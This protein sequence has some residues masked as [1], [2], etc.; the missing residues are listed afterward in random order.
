M[1]DDGNNGMDRRNVLK[2]T[3]STFGLVAAGGV[4]SATPGR[5]P[6]PK[7]GE[8]L[9]G[10]SAGAG[11]PA[12]VAAEHAPE[13]ASVAH[14]ND[15]LRYAAVKFPEAANERARENFIEAVTKDKR[16][17]YAEP[18]GT[19]EALYTPNDPQFGD[20]YA[21]QQVNADDAWDTTLGSSS[22]TIAVID[23]GV[24]YDHSDLSSQFGSDKGQDFADGDGDPYPDDTSNEYHGTH[25]AGIAGGTTDNGTGV[26]GISNSTLLSARALDETGGGSFADIAD[27]I[28][29]A[30]DQ[31]ADVINMSLGASSGSSTIQNAVQ[32]AYNNGAFIAA[33]AGNSGPCSDCVGYP[34]AY[35]QC[36]AVS[37]LNSSEGLANF[38]STG[39]EVELAAPGANV[40][41]TTTDSR[42]SYEELSGTSMASP[43]VAGVAGLTLAQWDIDNETLRQHLNSTAVNVGL[44]SNEQGN[45]R[46]DAGNAISTDPGDGGDDPGDDPG[47]CGSNSTSGTASDSLS[48]YWDGDCWYWSWEFDDP[49]QI[50]LELD[51][52]S[53]ADFDLYV[54]EGTGSCP[55]TSSYTHAST[56]TNSQERI[57]I[58][59]P[60]A[61]APLYVTVD[62]YYGSGNY[63]LTFTE[64][65]T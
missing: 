36:V 4:V 27:A 39:S 20:Q 41:S 11:R 56:S 46:V 55:S 40:L 33:A 30:A 13:H 5:E 38:S 31:G 62:S 61:S 23:T 42:G 65:S 24:Q 58:D 6:G 34:A 7:E 2:L 64:K 14:E 49:C 47:T 63:D 28:E 50:V 32:Y 19:M 37:A 52:P 8:I 43:V 18:N 21:P 53:G 45:G 26:A 51:G 1:P 54:N 35:D 57:V 48:G 29:W 9:V 22:V 44:G 15:T 17:K 16:V 3:G 60:D 10:V 12:D 25:V 59:D